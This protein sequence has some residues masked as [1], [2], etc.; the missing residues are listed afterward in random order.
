M[1]ISWCR[2]YWTYKETL[3]TCKFLFFKNYWSGV[4]D[5]NDIHL[6]TPPRG[7]G[8]R[9]PLIFYHYNLYNNRTE[10]AHPHIKANHV[11]S[12]HHRPRTTHYTWCCS[13]VC[14]L[15]VHCIMW[16]TGIHTAYLH[17]LVVHRSLTVLRPSQA[18]QDTYNTSMWVSNTTARDFP[19]VAYKTRGF[20]MYQRSR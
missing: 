13:V 2:Q 4:R 8:K 19:I 10:E 12:S 20:C 6:T 5:L 7:T 17:V 18:F 16:L 14:C 11:T 1:K 15:V 3:D 9:N